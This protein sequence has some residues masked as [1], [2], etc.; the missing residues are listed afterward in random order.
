MNRG[1]A[2]GGVKFDHVAKARAA[3]GDDLRD[4]V[5]AIAESASRIGL[6]ATG[7]I[8]GYSQSVISQVISNTYAKGNLDRV[9]RA[10]RAHLLGETVQCPGYAR[11][12]GADRCRDQQKRPFSSSSPMAARLHE[13]C[14]TCSNREVKS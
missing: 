7:Q 13:A 12:I 1:P 5:Q 9:E 8:L 2:P 4:F 11:I 14:R 6:K 3:W 10:A